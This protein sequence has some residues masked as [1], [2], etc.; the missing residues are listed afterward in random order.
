[1]KY[2]RLLI[3]VLD[4]VYVSVSSTIAYHIRIFFPSINPDKMQKNT[5]KHIGTFLYGSRYR[6]IA[7]VLNFVKFFYI[8]LTKSF[9]V[10]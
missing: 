2:L 9:K 7:V 8:E 4:F 3:N 6:K 5:K 10:K 1:M